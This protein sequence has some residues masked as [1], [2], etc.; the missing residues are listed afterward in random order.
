MPPPS[1]LSRTITSGRPSRRAASRP[2]TSWASA[3]SPI[4]STVG[5]GAGGRDAERGRDGAVDAV[6]AAVGEH[7]RRRRRGRGRTS[8][9]RAPAS[10]RRRR[11][12]RRPAAA[13]RARRPRAAR[14]GRRASGAIAPAAARS[15]RRQ[16]SSQ[17][18]SLRGFSGA[19]TA[20]VGGDDRADAPRRVLPRGLGV[21]GDLE[22]VEAVQP[23]AQRLGGREVAEAQDEVGGVGGGEAGVAQQRVV[24]GDRGRAAARAR[25]RLG[26]Q[27]QREPV[28]ERGE[29]RRRARGR[30]RCGPPP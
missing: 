26:E 2:P 20:R 21:E 15:A 10:R 24:V 19:S 3:T 22:R 1:L 16:P 27:R 18:R 12:S 4:S 11:A 17:P 25:Q 29:R 8:R 28:G 30:A 6:G 9:R 23:L 7:P 5:P 14:R 13:R